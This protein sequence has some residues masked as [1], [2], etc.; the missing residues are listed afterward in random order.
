MKKMIFLRISKD[1]SI[2]Q[3][4]DIISDKHYKIHCDRD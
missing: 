1:F 2:T 4:I 3:I